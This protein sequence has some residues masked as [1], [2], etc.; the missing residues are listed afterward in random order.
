MVPKTDRFYES[1]LPEC[2]I[3]LNVKQAKNKNTPD[4]IHEIKEKVFEH[5]RYLDNNPGVAFHNIPTIAFRNSDKME[6]E[7]DKLYEKNLGSLIRKRGDMDEWLIKFII[8]YY[9]LLQ[10]F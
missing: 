8:R 1:Y 10:L 2:K 5:L 7:N 4:Y 3:H 6:D 9:T